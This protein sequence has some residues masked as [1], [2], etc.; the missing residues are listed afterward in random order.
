MAAF[1]SGGAA[2]IF[3]ILWT[4]SLIHILGSTVEATSAIF[5]AFI[6][7][8]AVGAYLF[9]FILEKKFHPLKLYFLTEVG[10]AVSALSFGMLDRKSVV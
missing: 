9:T 1:L 2:L 6:L 3:E 10:I 8:L 4:R 5:A 7:G